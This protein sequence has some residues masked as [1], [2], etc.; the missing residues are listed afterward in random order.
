MGYGLISI[1]RTH[2]KLKV[3]VH[4]SEM[5]DWW[6]TPKAMFRRPCL[7]QEDERQQTTHAHTCT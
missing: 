3:L 5:R 4:A 2:R 1:L 7:T 6:G